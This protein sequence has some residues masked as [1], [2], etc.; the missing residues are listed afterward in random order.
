MKEISN[1]NKKIFLGISIL[2]F[3]F[4]WDISFWLTPN[5]KLILADGLSIDML[6]VIEMRYLVL[7]PLI[8]FFFSFIKDYKKHIK[9]L[10]FGSSFFLIFILHAYINL[11]QSLGKL[12]F[13][14]TV[15]SIVLLTFIF[16]IC[17]FY[18]EELL[19][20]LNKIVLLFYFLFFISIITSLFFFKL[21]APSFCGGITDYF[22][23]QEWVRPDNE[24][25]I[26][27][28]SF[29]EY[30]F[31][32]NSHLGMIAPAIIYYSILKFSYEKNR[33]FKLFLTSIFIIVCYIKSST[34]FLVGMVIC[35]IV[36]VLFD[37]R[38][39]KKTLIY[40]LFFFIALSSFILIND[41]ECR[42]RFIP[43]Y[44]DVKI[45]DNKIANKITEWSLE[46]RSERGGMSSAVFFQSFL[47]GIHSFKNKPFG[48]GLNQYQVA[49]RK[50]FEENT[51]DEIVGTKYNE[52]K[53]EFL[54]QINDKDAS[55]N[56]VKILTEFGIFGVLFYLTIFI[57]LF[58]QKI[59]LEIKVFLTSI[60]ITQTIR[61]AG[62]FN[63]GFAL[64][65]ILLIIYYL[66]T[67]YFVEKN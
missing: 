16:H 3:F 30:F 17:F 32:E 40:I 48:V 60:I 64:A 10:F 38:R 34:T 26:N 1:F 37:Y 53:I 25:F 39:I 42:T 44:G 22:N 21:D 11:D 13:K 5:Y 46:T 56:F 29:Q 41:R 8:T 31:K 63:G 35:G 7:L 62:Y 18:K 36:I 19:F 59:N 43:A 50:Y 51:L 24:N 15:F 28:L 12:I 33:S 6:A 52:Y 57:I 49:F 2:F 55:N 67:H 66:Y 27:D 58:S 23:F 47:I 54:N 65:A 4:L 45:V 9:Y 20:N 61:G 14:R